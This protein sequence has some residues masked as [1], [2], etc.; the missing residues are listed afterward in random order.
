MT[1][2]RL[3]GPLALAALA[4][5]AAAL[6]GCGTE[7]PLAPTAVSVAPGAAGTSAV[8]GAAAGAGSGDVPATPDRPT[9]GGSGGGGSRPVGSGSGGSGGGSTGGAGSGADAPG[10][11]IASF[12]VVSQPTCPVEG[13]PDAPFSSPGTPVTIAWSV[14]G[15]DGAAIAVDNPGLYGAYG[16][17]YPATGQLELPFGCDGS[18]TTTHTFTVWPAGAEGTS[19]TIT[20]S[21][22]ANG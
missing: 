16:R 9:A 1:P 5:T 8:S 10:P 17:S 21:A 19:K 22:R 2:R 6:T 11:T 14:T 15:A 12:R 3:I 18:G 4:A 20:V 7:Y 13:T